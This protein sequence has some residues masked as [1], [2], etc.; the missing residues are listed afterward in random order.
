MKWKLLARHI[1][2]C[3][4]CKIGNLQRKYKNLWSK[5]IKYIGRKK[6]GRECNNEDCDFFITEKKLIELAPSKKQL[7]KRRLVKK[8]QLT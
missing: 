4:Q 3:P 1:R 2:K 5:D 8:L 6:T 7:K